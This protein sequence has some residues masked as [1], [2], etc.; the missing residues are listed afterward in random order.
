MPSIAES[1]AF[2]VVSD[3]VDEGT[4][5]KLRHLLGRVPVAVVSDA[6]SSFRVQSTF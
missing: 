1:K 4:H 2:D 5:A 6:L 3:A